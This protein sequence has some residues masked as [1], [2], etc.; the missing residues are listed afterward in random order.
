M[1]NRIIFVTIVT[2]LVLSCIAAYAEDAGFTPYASDVISGASVTIGN[3]GSTITATA[4]VSARTMSDQVG[5]STLKFQKYNNGTW[6]TVKTVRSVY[7]YDA[8]VYRG[9]HTYTG[10]SGEKYRVVC[11]FYVSDNGI[12]DTL[13]KTSS[14]VTL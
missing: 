8:T 5:I 4:S 3:D 10:E 1:N 14:T 6:I 13:S 11:T 2:L 9:S 12:S 7:K